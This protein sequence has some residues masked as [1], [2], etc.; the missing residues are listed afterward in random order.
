[1]T[2]LMRRIT[3]LGRPLD[4]TW[5]TNRAV[6]VLA[7]MAALA[8][9][10]RAL[11]DGGLASPLTVG[12]LGGVAAF[13]GWALGRELD[14]DR[15]SVAFVAMALAWLAFVVEPRTSLLLPVVAL[16][17]ARLVNRTTG[18]PATWFDT[19]GAVVLVG[20]A[21]GETGNPLLAVG[22]HMAFVL[23]AALPDGVRRH[24]LAAPVVLALGPVAAWGL[25]PGA[26]LPPGGWGLPGPAALLAA[27]A[28][29]VLFVRTIFG[30]RVV[31][32]VGDD[33]GEPL[34]PSRV[35]GGMWASL[36]VAVPG[37]ALGDAG[38]VQAAVLWATMAGVALGSRRG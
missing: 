20:W 34:R 27:G 18:L 21:V 28:V 26:G 25:L 4:P 6:M 3:A 15:Q 30:T 10:V 11:L 23:D 9:W 13:L 36:A 5:A 14:P 17:L 16:V 33:T 32:S 24:A 38:V 2:E 29:A 7:P 8:T 37:L 35:R 22:A 31:E 12:V 1:M 19:V